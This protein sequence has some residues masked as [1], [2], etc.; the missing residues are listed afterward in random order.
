MKNILFVVFASILAG[1]SA[2]SQD[3]YDRRKALTSEELFF[4]QNGNKNSTG[5]AGQKYM[6]LDASPRIGKFR[7][8]R[9]F[10]GDQVKFRMHNEKIRFKSTISSITDSSFT[11]ANEAT[12]KMDN[13]EIM[14]KE[15]KL[16]KVSKR[17]P[18][19]TE[20]AYYFPIAGLLFIGAD[21][22]N[23]G[24]DDKRFTTDASAIL[25]GGALMAA[26]FVCYKM[27]FA[28]LKINERN[29]IKVL[30]TY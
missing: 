15:V 29:T 5:V 25:V 20:A 14:L 4:K 26:G 30:E 7:R 17:I 18:F 6:V 22:V 8:F 13:R 10:P 12:G 28:S 2:W 11:L 16:I 24:T 23:K 9:F 19:V 27:S 21:L 1:P 3:A